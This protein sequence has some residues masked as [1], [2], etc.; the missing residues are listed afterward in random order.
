MS[1]TVSAQ[2]VAPLRT[3]NVTAVLGPTN[4]GKTHLAIERMLAHQTGMIGLPL[5]LLAREVYDRVVARVGPEAV[6][7]VTG[8]ERI[9]PAQPRYWVSTVEAMPRDIEVD[10]LAVDEV[11]LAADAER[12]H[13]FTERLLHARGRQET[14]LL[15]SSTMREAIRDLLPGANF[16]SRPRLSKLTYAG[17]KKLSRLP[18]RSAIVAFSANDVYEIAELIRR[19]RG[20]AA[21]VLGA[22]S[23][24]TRNAQVKLYQSGDVEYLVAT[25]AIGMGLNLNVDHVAFAGIRKFDGRGHREITPAEI[26]QIAGR[27][28]RHMNDGT[29]GVTAD[30]PPFEPE[31][32]DR[33]EKH[34]FESVKVLQWRSANLD[35]SSLDNLKESLRAIPDHQRLTRARSADDVIALETLAADPDV[36]AL[37]RTPAAIERLWEVCQVPDY[38]KVAPQTHAELIGTLY[39]F[40]ME[41]NGRIPEDWFAGQVSQAARTDGDIDTLAT[42]IA[43]IRT[44]TFVSNRADWLDRPDYWQGRT[45]E[46]EDTLSDAMHEQLTQRFV[47]KRTSTL[48]RAMRDDDELDAVIGEDGAIRVEDH[49]VGRLAGFRFMPDLST[50]AD[51]IH[52]K[53]ARSA[54]LQVLDKELA[55]KVRRV[56]AAR[57]EAFK[58]V[59]PARVEWRGEE[60][61]R[62]EATDDPL[63]PAVVVLADE[64]VSPDDRAKVQSRL[65]EWLADIVNERLKPLIEIGSAE[66][67]SGLAKGIGFRLREGFGAL[68]RDTAAEDLKQLDQQARAQLRKYGVRFGAFNVYIPLLLK[69]AASELLFSLWMLKA[70][71][72]ASDLPEP[73]RAG[74]TSVAAD[75]RAGEAFYRAAG[76]HLCGPRAVRLDML[77]RLADMIRPLV[78]WRAGEGAASTPPKGATGDGGFIVTPEMMS[79]LGCS[80]DELGEVL[81]S[82]GFWSERKPKPKV[83]VAATEATVS[84]SG[85]LPAEGAAPDAAGSDSA[86]GK[87]EDA[88]GSS[89]A[90]AQSAGDAGAGAKGAL[91]AADAGA[92]AEGAAITSEEAEYIVVWRPRRRRHDEQ[93]RHRDRRSGRRQ[94]QTA[95]GRQMVD[96]TAASAPREEQRRRPHGP[97][98]ERQGRQGER[99]ARRTDRPGND[100]SERRDD[101]REARGE[102]GQ[103]HKAGRRT[104]ERGLM[105]AGPE[106]RQGYDPNSPFAALGALKE[107]LEQ[108]RRDPS[109][110]T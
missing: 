45:R 70:G 110:S 44:W 28:G 107:A 101:R 50:S 95:S 78:A 35:Y 41:G 9:K 68:R 96:A 98:R 88:A 1:S 39:R 25:D 53:A 105:Q 13:V 20:G 7:L 61:A 4:T 104:Q 75:V 23:P 59:R 56:V 91:A 65:E 11:Q 99:E 90:A 33:L 3:R 87:P 21:V 16:V 48:M 18:R 49:Y 34:E 67:V 108:Q 22:L 43:H 57:N 72:R 5:R 14:L 94:D 26:G 32:I 83:V 64:H 97:N 6:A 60:I 40:L 54:A 12:G 51:S 29:F 37:A 62:L 86:T 85:E 46:I 24:R 55:M 27:A 106:K 93:Y 66:D 30:V 74:L 103:R 58:L 102:R 36:A 100:R 2:F 81:K 63:K 17:Q 77:E 69:P 8:E 10:F 79:I 109:S 52:G 80:E 31:L 89:A 73:P 82:L 92:Q 47:D 38:R 42:R 71:E 19:H 76:Y 84:A 15:G